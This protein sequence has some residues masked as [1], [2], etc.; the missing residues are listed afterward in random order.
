[1][2]WPNKQAAT[3]RY[4]R[5]QGY[6]LS[7]EEG[8]R[9]S[10][11]LP[12]S[13]AGS[14]HRFEL[15]RHHRIAVLV[16]MSGSAGI[17]GPSCISCAQLAI[18][19]VNREK[20]VHGDCLEPVFL[21]SDDAKV[22]VLERE[23]NALVEDGT[24]SAVVSMCVSSVRQ[25]LNKV[26]AG[27]VPFVYT[28]LYE[29]REHSPNVFTIG[30]TPTDQL[31]PA[32]AR[33]SAMLKA[34]RWA[35]IGNDYVWPRASHAIAKE[36][37][38]QHGG[39]VVFEGYVPFGLEEPAWLVERI[40]R[41]EPDIVLVSLVGQDAV[42]FNRVFGDMGLDRRT[43]RFSPAMEENVLLA[44]GAGNS[45]RLFVASSY[46]AALETDRALA[47]RESYQALHSQAAPCLNAL[48]QSLYE[49]IQF[50]ASLVEQRERGVGGPVTYNSARG[51]LFYS[52][53]RKCVPTFLARADGHRFS[54][55]ESLA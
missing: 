50:Y 4:R 54:I 5:V 35:L 39:A 33:L 7:G 49:G 45:R 52:N 29:G 32:I 12:E 13:L 14:G 15:S 9:H 55:L 6:V 24:V 40:A 25:R 48:G 1:M 10:N 2:K 18:A 36:C 17:W 42:E 44:T 22:S 37:I 46:F 31:V 51:G 53:D 26:L 19:E 30:E 16:P 41:S 11:G 23:L 34:R 3:K 20:G 8:N 47:F 28:P 21:N 27:R 38:A 43:A